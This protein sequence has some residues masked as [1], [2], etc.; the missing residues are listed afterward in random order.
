[1]KIDVEILSSSK[2]YE[3]LRTQWNALA[4]EDPVSLLG[5]DGTSTYEWF[6]TILQAFPEAAE[7]LVIVARSGG[8]AVGFL[9]M[10][11]DR[12]ARFGPRLL[13]A[14][15][16]YG[17]RNGPLLREPKSVVF[18][19]MLDAIDAACPG[20][21]TLQMTLRADSDTTNV[22]TQVLTSGGFSGSA[23]PHQE[24]PYFPLLESAD[25]FKAGISKSVLQTI[26][27]S[28]NKFAKIGPLRC[29]E[30]T[31]AGEAD[32]LLEVVLAIEHKSWK[33]EAGSAITTRPRQLAFYRVL[34]PL[35]MKAK[36]LYAQVLFLQDEPIAYNFGLL[37]QRV[38]ACLKHSNI[39]AYDKL[40]PNYVLNE[41]LFEKL[42]NLG[43]VAIDWMGLTEPHKLRWS[44]HNGTYQRNTWVFYNRSLKAHFF[45]LFQRQ[46]LRLDR[47]RGRFASQKQGAS[48]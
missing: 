38:F 2:A 22:V 7:S 6:E 44:E 9:P 1:M 21:L 40:S 24:S 3:G 36:L 25:E 15:E 13:A 32:E 48:E 34:F 47:L 43:V 42:R 35:A 4:A 31:D 19:A 23:V 46:K 30:Y 18:T 11:V 10:I 45:N 20:W 16:L 33:H 8:E 26:R 5:M 17:G 37:H 14:T 28:R 41:S 29:R 39:Q 12:K 27:T